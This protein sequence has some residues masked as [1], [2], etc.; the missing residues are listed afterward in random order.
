[1]IVLGLFS[2]HSVTSGQSA[3]TLKTFARGNANAH[4]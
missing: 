1:V 3:H 4:G 2:I